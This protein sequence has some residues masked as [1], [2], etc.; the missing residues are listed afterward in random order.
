MTVAEKIDVGAHRH[1]G[2]R[3]YRLGC[4]CTDCCKGH[5]QRLDRDRGRG[6]PDG[7]LVDTYTFGFT[8]PNC[9]GACHHIN[10]SRPS[11]MGARSTALAKCSKSGCRR[12]WQLIVVVQP[13]GKEDR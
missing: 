11:P 6:T 9:G 10:S 4:R 12:T 8:C 5:E 1:G 13:V 3:A 2:M 7:E